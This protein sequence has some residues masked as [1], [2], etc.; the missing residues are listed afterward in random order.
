MAD[1][2]VTLPLGKLL[3]WGSFPQYTAWHIEY[4][5]DGNVIAEKGIDIIMN[6]CAEIQLSPSAN[7]P[8][9]HL[10]KSHMEAF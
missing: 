3:E 9:N 2:K 5:G 7:P 1:I 10:S 4:D 6:P 8:Q